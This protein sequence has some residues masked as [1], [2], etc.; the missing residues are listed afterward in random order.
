MRPCG[1]VLASAACGAGASQARASAARTHAE[2]VGQ[3]GCLEQALAHAAAAGHSKRLAQRHRAVGL[4]QPGAA[5]A[6]RAAVVGQSAGLQTR[7]R[8]WLVELRARL[9][10]LK[11]AACPAL[12]FRTTQPGPAA[13]APHFDCARGRFAVGARAG[14]CTGRRAQRFSAEARA[15]QAGTGSRTCIQEQ[16]EPAPPPTHPP[17]SPP[18]SPAGSRHCAWLAS[19]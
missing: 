18:H 13:H 6:A 1:T 19:Q 9:A 14:G 17:T 3:V 16:A 2:R 5:A 12:R 10:L 11:R 4:Q 15:A 8:V 7:R